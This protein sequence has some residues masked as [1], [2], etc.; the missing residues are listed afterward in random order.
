MTSKTKECFEPPLNNNLT[1]DELYKYFSKEVQTQELYLFGNA[2]KFFSGLHITST[3]MYPECFYHITTKKDKK[4]GLRI[5]EK[6]RFYINHIVPMI[7]H[8][9]DCKNCD[10]DNCSKIKM[11]SKPHNN[12]ITR[13]KLLYI[14]DTYNY[15]IILENDHKNKNQLNVVTSYLGNEEWFLKTTLA[16]YNKYKK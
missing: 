6:R 3:S 15:M 11:W 14:G 8:I 2:V 7:K 4:T 9:E 5:E 13:T 12:R 10:N 1:M 16:E